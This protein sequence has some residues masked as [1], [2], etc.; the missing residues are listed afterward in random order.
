M[1][2]RSNLVLIGMPGCGKSTLGRRLAAMRGLRFIDTDKLIEAD[3]NLPIQQ[4]VNLRGVAYLR[5]VEASV[6]NRLDVQN[7]IIATGGSAVYSQIAMQ[8]LAEQGVCIYLEISLATLMRRVKPSQNRGLAK[9]PQHPLPRLYYERLPLYQ[10]VADI[11]V[12]N[13]W[14][15]TAV[16]L[17]ILN[18][19][20]N[21]YIKHTSIN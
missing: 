17:S 19:R 6:L 4:I 8:H 9:L 11:T 21:D 12:N 16:R 14:P 5:E 18:R 20:I 10:A 1:K 7:S 15:L 3:Q 13:N 2:T